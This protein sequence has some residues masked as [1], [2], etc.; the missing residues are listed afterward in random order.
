MFGLEIKYKLYFTIK[1]YNLF[2][3]TISLFTV[4][5][6]NPQLKTYEICIDSNKLKKIKQII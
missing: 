5:N 1:F 4:V 6:L 2:R 3:S